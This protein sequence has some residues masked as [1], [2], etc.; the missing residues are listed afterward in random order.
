[1]HDQENGSNKELTI[2]QELSDEELKK[3][4]LLVEEI[5]RQLQSSK[6]RLNVGEAVDL[7]EQLNGLI[8][9]FVL[10]EPKISVDALKNMALLTLTV[11]VLDRIIDAQMQPSELLTTIDLVVVSVMF[12]SLCGIVITLAAD[13]VRKIDY[14]IK[15]N[16]PGYTTRE[17][18]EVANL[19]IR[20]NKLI[21]EIEAL[22]IQRS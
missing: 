1:M 12:L 11:P 6:N 22:Q 20:A 13:I 7:I 4:F 16:K 9:E 14:G 2:K 18:E 3:A 8:D 19:I 15:C 10:K 17:K 5:T 21:E